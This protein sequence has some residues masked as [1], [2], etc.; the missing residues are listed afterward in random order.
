MTM[1]TGGPGTA[2]D[3]WGA[4][5]PD[6]PQPLVPQ[7]PVPYQPGQ[8]QPAWQSAVPAAPS[9]GSM[10]GS[11]V[12]L[13][14]QPAAPAGKVD[15]YARSGFIL[16]FIPGAV[17]LSLLCNLYGLHRIKRDGNRGRRLAE[18]GLVLNALWIVVGIAIGVA[19]V[20]STP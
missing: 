6:Q 13:P 17:L 16:A 11:P 14:F 2:R 9:A 15:T 5:R 3:S 18:I 7:Q 8:Q 10:V 19:G 12:M 4:P 20:L 1:P